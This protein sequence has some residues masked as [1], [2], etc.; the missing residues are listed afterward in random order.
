MSYAERTKGKPPAKLALCD[1]DAA[2]VLDFL[3]HLETERHNTVR[4]R[5][6]RFPAVR[7]FAEYVA[8]Q[9]PPALQLA[10]Q[11]LAIPM[12]RFERPLLGYL[13]RE[14]VQALLEAPDAATRCGRRIRPCSRCFITLASG[15]TSKANPCEKKGQH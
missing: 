6:A 8:V 1:F 7:A 11:I 15:S 10:Q 4:S 3:D 14:E 2:M 12:K 5:S 9:C 13:S